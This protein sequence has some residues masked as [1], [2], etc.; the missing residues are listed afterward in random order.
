M[1]HVSCSMNRGF[2]LIETVIYLALFSIIIGGGMVATWHIIE[3]TAAA[4]NHIMLQE[5]AN[6]LLRKLN[7]ALTGKD[8]TAVTMPSPAIPYSDT[9]LRLVG[10]GVLLT[11][12]LTDNILTLQYGSGPA[13]PLTASSIIISATPS[14]HVF[15]RHIE[16]GKPDAITVNFTLTTAQNGR[17]ATQNFSITKY[18]RQ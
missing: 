10:D 1:F 17:P 18:L 8:Q 3:A 5:E 2:T 11:F 16:P 7:W 9:T 13:L 4:Q 15:E 14:T 6:F 12:A